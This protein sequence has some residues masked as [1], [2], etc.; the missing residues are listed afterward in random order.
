MK[1]IAINIFLCCG[2]VASIAI[3]IFILLTILYHVTHAWADKINHGVLEFW[4][5]VKVGK[6]VYLA[7]PY[8][9][10]DFQEDYSDWYRTSNRILNFR[11][12]TIHE[13]HILSEK[14]FQKLK[15]YAPENDQN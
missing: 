10:P 11:G 6:V 7:R 12:E 1:D 5:R 14:Q 4:Y 2:I 8:Q 13:I 3:T 15:S 9:A